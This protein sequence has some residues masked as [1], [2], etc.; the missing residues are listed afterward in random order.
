[1]LQAHYNYFLIKILISF[2]IQNVSNVA[3]QILYKETTRKSEKTKHAHMKMEI[4]R[5]AIKTKHKLET[6]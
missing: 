4:N 6:A 3:L 2:H 1:M 5:N